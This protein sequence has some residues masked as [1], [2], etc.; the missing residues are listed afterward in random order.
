MINYK[1]IYK[2]LYPI[3][4][5]YRAHTSGHLLM[6]ATNRLHY[7]LMCILRAQARTH[8]AI[9]SRFIPMDIAIT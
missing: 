8:I 5:K 6:F 3:I 1:D 7:R 9:T 2:M 4:T